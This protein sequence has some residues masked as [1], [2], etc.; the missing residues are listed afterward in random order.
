MA[1]AS[2]PPIESAALLGNPQPP[3]YEETMTGPQ[4]P[5]GIPGAPPPE[6]RPTQPPYPTQAY[7]QSYPPQGQPYVQSYQPQ[8][9]PYMYP[10]QAYSQPYH[11]PVQAPPPTR[12][13]VTVQTT[14]VQSGMYGTL[15]V[16]T[17][18]PAC[19]Q[20]VITQL[21]YSSGNAVWL[22][23]LGLC[24]FGC[25]PFSLIPFCVDSLKDVTHTCP[26]CR[27]VLGV[28]RRL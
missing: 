11:P 23:C 26:N 3:T 22:L 2:A 14:V 7:V 27:A 10:Q 21:D 1:M 28:Y 24:M 9:Q 25:F 18:C 12:P 15:P 20:N 19:A 8:G 4:S 16:Q 5:Q 6:Y 13:I 17:V